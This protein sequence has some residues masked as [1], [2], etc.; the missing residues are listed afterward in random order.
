MWQIR[1]SHNGKY[2]AGCGSHDKVFI[3][4]MQTFRLA[5]SLNDLKQ[6]VGNIAWSPD[7]TKLVTCGRD[8]YARIWD[9]NVSESSQTPRQH[10]C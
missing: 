5:F 2:L 4:D 7:D 9:M 1:F 6:G 10:R 8:G 3:W